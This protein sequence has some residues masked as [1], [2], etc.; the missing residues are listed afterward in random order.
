MP[1]P[2]STSTAL[3]QSVGVNTH[4]NYFNL[5][6]GNALLVATQLKALGLVHVRDGLHTLNDD[7]DNTLFTTW[8]L[9]ARQGIS[10][11]AVVDPR[12]D[13]GTLTADL[14]NQFYWKSGMSI[15]CLEGPNEMDVSGEA[16][17][18]A[19]LAAYQ[20]PLYGFAKTMAQGIAMPVIAPSMAYPSSAAAA[21][22][23]ECD[24]GNW[25][26]Y[27]AGN[28][29]TVGFTSTPAQ[30]TQLEAIN[31]TKPI[32]ATESGYHNAIHQTGGQPGV[33]EI[34]AAKYIL[35][36]LLN[37]FSRGIVRTYLYELQ[38]EG[39]DPTLT[40]A[41]YAWGMIRW[42]GTVKPVYRAV[43]NLLTLLPTNTSPA[44]TALNYTLSGASVSSLLLQQSDGTWLLFL[45]QEISCYNLT[46]NTDI[47]NPNVSVI[48]TLPSNCYVA[49]YE[50]FAQEGPLTMTDSSSISLEIGDH[51]TAVKIGKILET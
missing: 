45:W 39:S 16:N 42:D 40:N 9:I 19:V 29:P 1:V 17:W 12:S 51:P 31:G 13:L 33:S 30:P 32:M 28:M 27:P 10:F 38:D 8:T 47:T 41:T 3:F 11:D 46:T 24:F 25:H 49:V 43:R 22:L 21:G 34:A 20:T 50:P 6:Y 37:N 14:L 15:E 4:L 35:R 2:F 48:L 26:Y 7:Y 36:L 5:N 18:P 44:L 23:M